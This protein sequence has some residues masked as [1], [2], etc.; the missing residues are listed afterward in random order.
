MGVGAGFTTAAVAA[1]RTETGNGLRRSD[2][3]PGVLDALAN[4][5]GHTRNPKSITAAVPTI[6]M[7]VGSLG[8]T[9]S[10]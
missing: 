2:E 4:T 6:V 5:P 9:V 10:E 8:W 1:F 7:V 3:K